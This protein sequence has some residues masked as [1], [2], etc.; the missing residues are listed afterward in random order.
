[1]VQ[2]HATR[3]LERVDDR[4]TALLEELLTLLEELSTLLEEP[5]TLLEELSTLL[6]ELP[7]QGARGPR[8]SPRPADGFLRRQRPHR[9]ALR[10]DAARGR[11]IPKI[12]G[13][14]LHRLER[15]D[16]RVKLDHV[17]RL[18]VRLAKAGC[19]EEEG[20]RRFG[21]L[22]ALGAEPVRQLL[23]GDHSVPR[24]IAI[25][26]CTRPTRHLLGKI[27][28]LPHIGRAQAAQRNEQA[29]RLA[30]RLQLLLQHLELIA[31]QLH[32]EQ[33]L[34]RRWRRARGGDDHS[35]LLVEGVHNSIWK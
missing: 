8:G 32:F 30:P 23:L 15:L 3:R 9:F 10:R 20:E 11:K 24:S 35:E 2:V 22:D 5:S 33:H 16:E 18:A 29:V 31:L 21:V 34:R 12:D 1:M 4:L 25:L 6:E 27:L 14:H 7:P 17:H 26:E 19:S 13:M 28:G